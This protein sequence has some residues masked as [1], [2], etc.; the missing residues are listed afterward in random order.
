[1]LSMLLA[2]RCGLPALVGASSAGTESERKES[3]ETTFR[4]LASL[5]FGDVEGGGATGVVARVV[6]A[7]AAGIGGVT[8]G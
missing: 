8:A 3:G 1:M 6:M 2:A 4:A 5:G 7:G